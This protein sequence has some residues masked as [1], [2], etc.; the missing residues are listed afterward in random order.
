MLY[1]VITANLS[2]EMTDFAEAAIAALDKRNAAR[3]AQPSKKEVENEPIKAALA[4]IVTGTGKAMIAKDITAAYNA[5]NA[6]AQITTQ[7]VSALLHQ[8]VDAGTLKKGEPVKKT[9]TYIGA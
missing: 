3:Q 5:A 1:E 6:D 7:K 2:K 9:L 4:A 8:L